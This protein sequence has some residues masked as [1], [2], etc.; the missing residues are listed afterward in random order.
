[1]FVLKQQIQADTKGAM[2]SGDSKAVAVLRMAVASMNAKQ[3][4]KRYKIAKESPELP[5][6]ELVKKFIVQWLVNSK[7]VVRCVIIER[8]H[9]PFPV[10][11][12][13]CGNNHTPF[14]PVIIVHHFWIHNYNVICYILF[15]SSKHL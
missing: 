2:K 5:E 7:N 8:H 12:M 6:E 15:R 1:M 11:I 9:G 13:P 10:Y 14:L 4:E 3:T